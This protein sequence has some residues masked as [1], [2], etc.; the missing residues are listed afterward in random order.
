MS[1]MENNMTCSKCGQIMEVWDRG[2][3]YEA[4]CEVCEPEK[5]NKIIEKP[6]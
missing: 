3:H 6:K 5:K 1:R 2:S 4:I